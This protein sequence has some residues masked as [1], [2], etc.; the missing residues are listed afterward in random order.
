MKKLLKLVRLCLNSI[1]YLT[2]KSP[3][4]IQAYV[5]VRF[6]KIVHSNWGDDLNVFLLERLTGKPIVVANESLFH[7]LLNI[8]TYICIGSVISLYS[9]SNAEIWGAGYIEKNENKISP[10][11]RILMVRGRATRDKLLSEGFACPEIY[12]DPAILV[13]KV[14]NPSKIGHYKIGLIP[15]VSERN[16]TL[17]DNVRKKYSNILY[18]DLENYEKWTDVVDKIYSCDIILSSSLHGLIVSDSYGV[19][20]VWTKFTMNEIRGGNFKFLDY[21]SS[22]ERDDKYPIIIET[23][24]QLID[25]FNTDIQVNKL[26]INYDSMIKS[27]PFSIKIDNI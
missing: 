15:H 8:P 6:G 1:V 13:S 23:E 12:G 9:K 27:C 10:A 14:Y 22:V 5:K 2:Y 16:S 18:I 17:L 3:L 11:K 4:V 21:F 7:K 26:N 25:Y 20:N 24:E 19:P